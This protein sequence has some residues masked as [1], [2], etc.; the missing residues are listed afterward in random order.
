MSSICL[1]IT[2]IAA[3]AATFRTITVDMDTAGAG[4]VA[5]ALVLC[6]IAAGAASNAAVC[7][8]D[9]AAAAT[10][11]IHAATHAAVQA[12]LDA[13]HALFH[14]LQGAVEPSDPLS[15]GFGIDA[16]A[17]RP[18]PQSSECIGC[19]PPQWRRCGLLVKPLVKV[20][21]S[22][23]QHGSHPAAHQVPRLGCLALP[24]AGV[25]PF[26]AWHQLPHQPQGAVL[27]QVPALSEALQHVALLGHAGGIGAHHAQGPPPGRT[28]GQ[29][30]PRHDGL[31]GVQPRRRRQLCEQAVEP[32]AAAQVGAGVR[33]D[34]RIEDAPE[35]APRCSAQQVSS[36]LD[37]RQ[38]QEVAHRPERCEG[39][40][41][42]Q[43]DDE[44]LLPQAASIY[45][46]LHAVV[47]LPQGSGAVL[48]PQ[49]LQQLCGPLVLPR[50]PEGQR[51][52][53]HVC[54]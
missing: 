38:P 53:G 21:L 52:K 18:I 32:N 50:L 19:T 45:H 12:V 28:H 48:L 25:K 1:T 8:V 30:H 27:G 17:L 34:G 44:G 31:R 36:Q 42:Q 22:V 54:P 29:H 47:R 23:V 3:P 26:L 33:P 35:A 7:I 16:D 43:R 37:G 51:S 15:Q 11:G 39:S 41:A 9:A 20:A 14:T 49:S 24:E 5:G 10:A 2:S 40:D 6:V 4:A 13:V 46:P